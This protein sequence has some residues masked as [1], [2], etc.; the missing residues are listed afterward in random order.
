MLVGFFYDCPAVVFAFDIARALALME[1]QRC[2]SSWPGPISSIIDFTAE[3]TAALVPGPPCCG[4]RG[5]RRPGTSSCWPKIRRVLG[6]RM[7]VRHVLGSAARA[8]PPS[9]CSLSICAAGRAH[10]HEVGGEYFS[11]PLGSAA[12]CFDGVG[13]V[14]T[15]LQNIVGHRAHWGR[16]IARGKDLRHHTPH[17]DVVVRML[18]R[19]QC[20][21]HRLGRP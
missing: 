19:A 13:R 14:R 11:L 17:V 4:S 8:L 12:K 10:A 7:R 21:P 5:V 9:S 6:L 18:W 3:T 2:P 15:C 20:R 16:W 1:S